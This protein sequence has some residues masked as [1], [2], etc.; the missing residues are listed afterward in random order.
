[1][2]L[3]GVEH[4]RPFFYEGFSGLVFLVLRSEGKLAEL[5]LLYSF[6]RPAHRLLITGV[7]EPQRL[8]AGNGALEFQAGQRT[9]RVTHQLYDFP[10]FEDERALGLFQGKVGRAGRV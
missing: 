1:V 7:H 5:L 2:F 9:A 6:E 10:P 3:D 8:K 4:E